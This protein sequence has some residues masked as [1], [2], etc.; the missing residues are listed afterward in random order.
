MLHRPFGCASCCYL[1]IPPGFTIDKGISDFC[2]LCQLHFQYM[3]WA[4]SYND[5]NATNTHL[6]CES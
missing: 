5:N 3:N 1:K 2:L 4:N 6:N